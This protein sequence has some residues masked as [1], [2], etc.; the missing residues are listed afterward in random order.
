M[1]SL[2]NTQSSWTCG[3]ARHTRKSRT[4]QLLIRCRDDLGCDAAAVGHQRSIAPCVSREWM[5]CNVPSGQLHETSR[6]VRASQ[7]HS[8]G[9]EVVAGQIPRQQCSPQS[10]SR[11][12]AAALMMKM[13]PVAPRIMIPHPRLMRDGERRP[14]LPPKHEAAHRHGT[15]TGAGHHGRAQG[16]GQEGRPAAA[17]TVDTGPRAEPDPIEGMSSG[18]RR[19]LVPGATRPSDEPR[20]AGPGSARGPRPRR[21][22]PCEGHARTQCI[23][24]DV[25][26]WICQE[27]AYEPRCSNCERESAQTHIT[28]RHL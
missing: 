13:K 25:R 10:A 28:H 7:C 15:S 24:P 8:L 26:K 19:A 22:H 21:S 12:L 3:S 20:A 17:A 4:S 14:M 27:T 23:I 9:L 16:L 11:W 2:R 1:S 18:A 5:G 6:A